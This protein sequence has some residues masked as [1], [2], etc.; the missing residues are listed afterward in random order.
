ML[1]SHLGPSAM[2][3]CQRFVSWVAKTDSTRD[4]ARQVGVQL[5]GQ[6]TPVPRS[7]ECSSLRAASQPCPQRPLDH[8][9]D[10]EAWGCLNCLRASSLKTSRFQ[11]ESHAKQHH[12]SP[13]LARAVLQLLLP[14]HDNDWVTS[15]PFFSI[16]IS[17]NE[18]EHPRFLQSE[19][20]D[21]VAGKK[22]RSRSKEDGKENMKMAGDEWS[23]WCARM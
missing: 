6:G 5:V 12:A 22:S 1:H 13:A 16:Q 11:T 21:S 9:Q 19:L 7:S 23:C 8:E 17:R 3:E 18:K 2:A 20:D 15:L 14:G 4:C 10:H